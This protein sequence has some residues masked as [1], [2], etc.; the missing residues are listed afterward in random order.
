MLPGEDYTQPD[1]DCSDYN[2][3]GTH[4][5]GIV[6]AV[7]GNGIG[8]K[9]VAPKC[10]IL[11]IRAGFSLLSDT[12]E[13]SAFETTAIV[14][15]IDY[16][17]NQGA[18]VISMSFTGARS[19][20]EEEAIKYAS[21]RN[22]I[23]IA[24]AGNAN[25]DV[26]SYPAGYDEVL[27][28]TSIN[29]IKSKS[30]FTTY[31]SWTDIAA[32]GEDI[33]STVP[34]TGGTFSDPS[35]YKNLSGTSMA[36][37]Y[38]AGTAALL[39][40]KNPGMSNNL[41]FQVLKTS[42]DNNYASQYYLGTGVINGY[43]VVSGSDACV[44]KITFPIDI[45]G[46][47]VS[48]GDIGISGKAFGGSFK[49]Y[50]FE[51]SNYSDSKPTWKSVVGVYESPVDSGYL[52]TVHISDQGIYYIRLKVVSSS[53]IEYTDVIGPVIVDKK[54]KANWIVPTNAIT[55]STPAIADIDKDGKMEVIV[56]SSNGEIFVVD[57]N[58]QNKPGWPVVVPETSDS[59]ITL[60]F[61]S[62]AV[63]DID[64]DGKDEIVARDGNNIYVYGYDG[65]MKSGWPKVTG[66]EL[67]WTGLMSSP[68]IA[69]IDNDGKKEI[70]LAYSEG[71]LGSNNIYSCLTVYNYN[72][73]IMSGWPVKIP[74][75][76]SKL[77]IATTPVVSDLD[78]D[79]NMEIIYECVNLYVLNK[80][81]NLLPGWPQV[82]GDGSYNSPIVADINNDGQNEIIATSFV[83]TS[84]IY[85]KMGVFAFNK[86]GQLLPGWPAYL[87]DR[88]QFGEYDLTAGIAAGDINN[89]GYKEIIIGSQFSLWALD[90][91]GKTI[92]SLA[93]N[94]YE[95]MQYASP[96]IADINGD[97]KPEILITKSSSV[98]PFGQI[99]AINGT[100]QVLPD[101]AL[102]AP[103]GLYATPA[104][105]IGGD[106]HLEMVG[107]SFKGNVF[108]WDLGSSSSTSSLICPTY[109]Y[110][111]Q[112][113]GSYDLP[114]VVPTVAQLVEPLSN[115][116]KQPIKA[117]FK[118]N[119]SI[120]AN[121]YCLQIS[122]NSSF[123]NI[124]RQDTA[125]SEVNCT[126]DSL[127]NGTKLFWRIRA[128][129]QNWVWRLVG[130]AKFNYNFSYSLKNS[131]G[132][133][134]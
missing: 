37:S 134:G 81:G 55:V 9:G 110:N 63:A 64:N 128:K 69:D 26:K 52:G 57:Q 74:V 10:K 43:K 85:G 56:T 91:M 7:G 59:K 29:K 78:G 14:N 17:V 100:G 40:S 115:L 12:Q 33:I 50:V 71:F 13:I 32:P 87:D 24:A 5:A 112:R 39:L 42:T 123:S 15:A 66:S 22:I 80:N 4:C 126:I 54:M 89:D 49:N 70:I 46:F 44:S 86:A 95:E 20:T 25:S 72:G 113:T 92:W 2:G 1:N 124:V 36:A 79:G 35:G 60:G 58:G 130:G 6:A 108:C 16:A 133:A 65:K 84:S 53:N 75:S 102:T 19:N 105:A 27:A 129:K 119:P 23:L 83:K 121:S 104:I 125:I 77:P 41:A 117:T 31:G 51:Y 48:N 82:I 94:G 62:P 61:S 8:V 127:P 93:H 98:A 114:K 76:S 101:L 34:A 122:D 99:T 18:N 120:G 106:N 103:E 90:R 96:V 38:V 107:A 68:V 88:T 109:Q 116:V 3:H 47:Y 73:D 118:W 21:C 30:S 45:K 131:F 132:Y 111:N 97:N 67:S 11:P 28:V